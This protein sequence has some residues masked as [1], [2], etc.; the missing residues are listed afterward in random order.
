MAN[1]VQLVFDD[2]ALKALQAA[3]ADSPRRF[4]AFLGSVVIPA[5][6]RRVDAVLNETPG[7]VKL[8]F[9]FATPK[10]R[11]WYFA[12]RKPPYKRTGKAQQW[13][14]VMQASSGETVEIYLENRAPHALWVF[15]SPTGEHQ[16]PGHARTGWKKLAPQIPVQ[17]QL[18]LADASAAWLE[19]AL[20][21]LR[22]TPST[23]T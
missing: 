21:P 1:S 16:V 9:Q 13:K 20:V 19:V 23:Q 8:P 6:Q 12:N 2:A 22:N 10:S 17:Q 11:R 7:A 18:L 4:T 5:A 14:L 15:G 3:V